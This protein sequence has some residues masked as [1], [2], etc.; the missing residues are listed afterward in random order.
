MYLNYSSAHE[1]AHLFI[2]TSFV[3]RFA[4]GLKN[5]ILKVILL[6][7]KKLK[8][9]SKFMNIREQ[10]KNA[11]KFVTRWKNRGKERSESQPFWIDL[12][13]G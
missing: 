11:K 3:T 8:K 6:Y 5:Y 12:P 9:V 10:R 2:R 1:L 13:T 7:N 4:R